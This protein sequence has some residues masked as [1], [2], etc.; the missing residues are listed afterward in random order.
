MSKKP[1][2]RLASSKARAAD[3]GPI[4]LG[5]SGRL[6]STAEVADRINV[7]RQ[8]LWTWCRAGKF[9]APKVVFGRAMW[10]QETI[11]QWIAALPTR[12]YR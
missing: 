3:Y 6:L 1:K 8:A 10:T 11:D 2:S 7:S 4:I 9:P 5:E 12:T